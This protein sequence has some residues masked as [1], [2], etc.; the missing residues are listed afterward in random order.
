MKYKFQLDK[1]NFET[2]IGNSTTF[3]SE[4]EI[5]I[6]KQRVNILI[7]EYDEKEI[8]SIF[9]DNRLYQVEIEKDIEG[10]PTGIYVDG[11]YYSANL[12]KIDKFFYYKEKEAISKK[13]GTVKS[14]IPGNI[15]KIFLKEGDMV[16]EG[17]LVLIHEAMKM[18]NEMRAPISGTIKSIG[19]K[20]GENILTNQL[21]FEIE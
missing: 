19:V 12:L 21:L 11:E 16:K 6:N 13:S 9:L 7:G 14:F 18:E 15:V 5:R 17:N 4:T 20:E 3:H 1:K 10:Y 2:V 8:R